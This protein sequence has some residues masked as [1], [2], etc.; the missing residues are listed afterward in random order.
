MRLKIF[1]TS[2]VSLL[3][4]SNSFA[5]DNAQEVLENIQ[6]KFNSINDLSARISSIR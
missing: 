1:F 6:A 5:Q 3:F 4:L 2:V